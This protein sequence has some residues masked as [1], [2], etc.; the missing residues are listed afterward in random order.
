MKK[1]VCDLCDEIIEGMP[2]T[3]SYED[4]L[5]SV[6]LRCLGELVTEYLTEQALKHYES[7]RE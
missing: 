2:Q 4:R 1:M 3:V 6:H 7:N 5:Y